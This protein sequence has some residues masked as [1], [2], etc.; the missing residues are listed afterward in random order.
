VKK[1]KVYLNFYVSCAFTVSLL[2]LLTDLKTW[3]KGILKAGQ[4]NHPYRLILSG[5]SAPPLVFERMRKGT[6]ELFLLAYCEFD[7]F[8][9]PT[10]LGRPV[11]TFSEDSG[12]SKRWKVRRILSSSLLQ[13]LYDREMIVVIGPSSCRRIFRMTLLHP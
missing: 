1:A 7:P 6:S 5:S 4:L 11:D 2:L 13:E 12:G 10:F 3:D 8:F 9:L